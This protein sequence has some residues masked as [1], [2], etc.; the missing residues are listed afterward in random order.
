MPPELLALRMALVAMFVI[1]VALVAERLGTFL[2]A[3]VAS[4]PL[5]TGP[6]YLMLALEHDAGYLTAATVNS[7]AICGAN[8]VY[9]LIYALLARS[10]GAGLSI[11]GALIAWGACSAVVLARDWTL[12][13]AL[14]FVAPIYGVSLWLAQDFT[15]GIA[16]RRAARQW[17]DLAQRAIF[18]ALLTGVVV[19][20][21]RHVPAS[22]TGILSVMPILTTSLVLVMHPRVGGP[23]TAAL[24]AHSLGGLVGMVV[25]FAVVHL[26]LLPIGV[27]PSLGLGL[28]VTVA[29]NVMLI[30][31]KSLGGRLAQR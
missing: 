25:A 10:R 31:L 8:P 5:Y 29:W 22:V 30:G 18:V 7:V 14:L 9:V 4:L 26:T 23:P 15:R 27:W 2:G 13:E 24:L 20:S 28:A 6:V 21:S 16:I 17:T 3:M 12:P 1:V 11:L 19:I